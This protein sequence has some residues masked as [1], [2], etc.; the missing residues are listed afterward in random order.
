MATEDKTLERRRHERTKHRGQWLTEDV[1]SA[2]QEKVK[3]CPDTNGQDI[4]TRRQLRKELQEQYGLLEIE[5]IN[6]LNGIHA[7]FYI[8]KYRR[9][10][11]C[12][13]NEKRGEL[14]DE[15]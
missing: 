14:Q 15:L 2:Y 13:P 9:M 8:E 1:V 6:I 7:A 5:A 3:H 11:D 10:K 4:G 12:L